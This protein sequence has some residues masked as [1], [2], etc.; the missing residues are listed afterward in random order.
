MGAA[1]F[2]RID[3]DSGGSGDFTQG[4][5]GFSPREQSTMPDHPPF[6]ERVEGLPFGAEVNTA[7][8]VTDLGGRLRLPW[9]RRRH[10]FEWQDLPWL[11]RLFRRFVTDQLAFHM[12]RAYAPAVPL[13][14]GSLGRTRSRR[15]VDLCS[16]SGG[17]LPGLHPAIELAVGRAVRVTLT[18]RYPNRPAFERAGARSGGAIDFEPEAVG[19]VVG[20]DL[21]TGYRTLF[22]SLHHFRPG[23][24]R[25]LLARAAEDG[26]PIAAFEVQDRGLPTLVLLPLFMGL[27]SLVLTPFLPGRTPGRLLFTYVI[28]LAPLILAWDTF[29]SCWRTYTPAELATLT[30]SLGRTDYH[31]RTG[32]LA[33]RGYFGPYGVTWLIG[34]PVGP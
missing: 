34:E 6:P 20:A 1:R 19:A 14:A 23:E 24:V 9:L 32:R 2:V 13:L 18:D 7:D 21:P 11:P 4:T 10:L 8:A 5:I 22:S 3:L 12:A 27:A 28:P 30:A 17:P 33:A 31:W 29:V 26:A 15:I 25:T 16:G